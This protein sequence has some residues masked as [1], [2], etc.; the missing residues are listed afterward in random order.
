[1]IIAYN[2]CY[3][4]FV[5]GFSIDINDIIH[6]IIRKLIKT[7]YSEEKNLSLL[8][9]DYWKG[10]IDKIFNVD[11]TIVSENS[12]SFFASSKV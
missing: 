8:T 7:Q 10:R 3:T 12:V 4:T 2:I 11:D 9:K 6:P 1:M 5:D